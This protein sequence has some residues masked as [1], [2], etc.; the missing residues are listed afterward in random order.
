MLADL[1][2]GKLLTVTQRGFTLVELVVT[3]V[4]LMA[5]SMLAVPAFQ[6]AIGNAQIRTV[7]ESIHNGLQQA[8]MEAIKRNAKIKFTLAT[9]S[10]WQ[11][12]C[13]TETTSCPALISQKSA[14]EGASGNIAVTADYY[15]AVFTGFGTR[16]PATDAGLSRVD[17]SNAQVNEQERRQ[18]R[19]LLAAGGY[20]RVCDPAVTTAGDARTC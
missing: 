20:A 18:L 6:T 19:I 16:D 11:F 10:A 4:V 13:E 14:S 7:A 15:T 2:F 9:S 12:G 8:R 1:L 5:V 3:V 17:V